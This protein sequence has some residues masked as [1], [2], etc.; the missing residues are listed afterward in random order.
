M[1]GQGLID[2]SDELCLRGCVRMCV[3]LMHIWMSATGLNV[4]MM[5]DGMD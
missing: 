1:S 5:A 2:S 4:D 3:F